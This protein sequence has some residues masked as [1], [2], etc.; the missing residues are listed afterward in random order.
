MLQLVKS[1]LVSVSNKNFAVN[2]LNIPERFQNFQKSLVN[3]PMAYKTHIQ[4]LQACSGIFLVKRHQLLDLLQFIDSD[5]CKIITK[6]YILSDKVAQKRILK[7]QIEYDILSIHA[8]MKK[9][10]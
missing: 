1:N 5:I 9:Q 6:K 4:H 2:G 7:D 8:S 3:Q 10:R